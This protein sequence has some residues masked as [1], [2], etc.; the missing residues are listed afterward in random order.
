L[1]E[2]E[3]KTRDTALVGGGGGGH[4]THTLGQ[5]YFRSGHSVRFGSEKIAQ[6]DG[7][8]GRRVR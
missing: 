1:N 5:E 3:P 8:S 6:R 7:E 2:T 4:N